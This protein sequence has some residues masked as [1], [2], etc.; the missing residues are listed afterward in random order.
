MVSFENNNSLTVYHVSFLPGPLE[1]HR[2]I[3]NPGQTKH[4]CVSAE[5]RMFERLFFS[6]LFS[7]HWNVTSCGVTVHNDLWCDPL[8]DGNKSLKFIA[9]SKKSTV[10]RRHRNRAGLEGLT[11]ASI[12]IP[13]GL[14]Y[15]STPH[16][17][18]TVKLKALST[19][20]AVF[21]WSVLS[22]GDTRRQQPPP[23]P[24]AA[25]TTRLQPLT[26]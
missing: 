10:T 14:D 12:L 13:L 19:N 7:F 22:P 20:A 18:Q 17:L 5:L 11:P 26:W 1:S 3:F 24:S 9:N 16:R 21:F 6:F 4:Q 15:V 2:G 8:S 23:P 25:P